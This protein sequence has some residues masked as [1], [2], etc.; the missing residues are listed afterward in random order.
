MVTSTQFQFLSCWARAL[1][2]NAHGENISG[3]FP[4]PL[5]IAP[6][7]PTPTEPVSISADNSLNQSWIGIDFKGTSIGI[8][9]GRIA[10]KA[11]I[12]YHTG[13]P[14]QAAAVVAPRDPGNT[15]GW[16]YFI[17]LLAGPEKLQK[18]V[19]SILHANTE[20]IMEFVEEHVPK[21]HTPN[22]SINFKSIKANQIGC[23]FA[24]VS[25][26][27]RKTPWMMDLVFNFSGTVEAMGTAFG[28]PFNAEIKITNLMAQLGI[29]VDTTKSLDMS[30]QVPNLYVHRLQCSVDDIEGLPFGG[31]GSYYGPGLLNSTYNREVL[32]AINDKL[33]DFV[34]KIGPLTPLEKYNL[35]DLPKTP[36]SLENYQEWMSKSHIQA[37]QLRQ[38]KIPGTHDSAAYTFDKKISYILYDE[39]KMLSNFRNNEKAPPGHKLDDLTNLYIGPGAYNDVLENIALLGQAHHESKTIKKQLEDGIRYLDLRIYL[40]KE[41]NDYYTQHTLRAPKLSD[42]IAQ[43]RGFLSEHILSQEFIIVEF[44]QSW[45]SGNVVS[46]DSTKVAN[47]VSHALGPWL[48]LPPDAPS[49]PGP[50]L[51]RYNFQKLQDL[52][53]SSITNGSPKVLIVSR[54]DCIYPHSILNVDDDSLQSPGPGSGLSPHWFTSPPTKEDMIGYIFLNTFNPS[55][56]IK[57]LQRV[58]YEENA[59]AKEV[60]KKDPPVWRYMMD[61]YTESKSGQL[62][63]DLIIK[64]NG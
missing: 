16:D 27:G 58:A 40:D 11:G 32:Q 59:S 64:A 28:L 53:L 7:I 2:V 37:K 60:I 5:T 31:P 41:D 34:S 62:P 4:T 52:Q 13:P 63:I 47:M 49:N 46:E 51:Q 9:L 55:G 3:E 56:R 42:V 29:T 39:L 24:A 21:L 48:Y 10:F 12:R 35:S 22:F 33:K 30:P 57:V 8:N 23:A 25:K 54:D 43:I 20:A 18:T 19:N 15:H 17:W 44:A 26:Q 50:E 45:F 38:L 1:G 14:G 36:P 6:A 61:W